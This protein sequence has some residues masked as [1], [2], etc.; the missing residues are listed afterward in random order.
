MFTK[1]IDEITF[2]DVESFCKEW[3]EGVR[4]EYKREVKEIKGKIPKIVSSFANFYGGIFFI[5]VEADKTKNEVIFPI[6]GIPPGTPAETHGIE[7]RIQQSALR[8]IYPGVMPEVKIVDV[9]NSENFVVVVRVDE[10]IQ[11]PHAIENSTQIY[12]RTGSTTEPYD[13]AEI[14]RISH[15]FKRREDSQVVAR[16]IL[17]RIE[18]RISNF[19]STFATIGG[20]KYMFD[21]LPTFTVITRPVFPY[22]PLTS[23]SNIYETHRGPLWPPRR[24]AGGH[25]C[26]NEKEYWE[27]NEY[28]IVYHRV[29]L[30]IRTG[31][32]IDYGIF[33]WRINELIKRANALYVDCGYQGNIEVTARLRNIFRRELIDTESY[34]YGSKITENLHADP[35]CYDSEVIASKNCLA[36]DLEDENE[37][38]ALVEELTCP[39]LWAFNI[40]IDKPQIRGKIRKRIERE[41]S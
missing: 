23:V 30:F 27:L 28:G 9:P 24:V 31:D 4:V 8:G 32:G 12:I 40:P 16:Q 10:S 11:A 37:Q 25:F 15:M 36:R 3:P 5:G 17:D 26:Y 21:N 34:S 41:F 35:M 39:L 22:R 14:D 2:D 20:G 7:E 19:A 6:Q 29:V 33:L 18:D 1:P 38:K 13:L